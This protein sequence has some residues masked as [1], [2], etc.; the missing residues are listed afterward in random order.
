MDTQLVTIPAFLRYRSAI[1][2]IP[3][4][5]ALGQVFLEVDD[6]E[7]CDELIH[8][9]VYGFNPFIADVLR[10]RWGPLFIS[11]RLLQPLFDRL[12]T[13]LV[14][15]PGQI[16]GRVALRVS[17]PS[18]NGVGL[19]SAKFTGEPN[20]R[21]EPAVRRL[22]RKLNAHRRDFGWLPVLR[23]AEIPDLG[24]SNHLAGGLPMRA[25]PGPLESD[26]LGR[27]YGLR[28]VHV[29]DGACFSDL[30]AEHLTYTIMANATRIAAQSTEGNL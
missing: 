13:M 4:A 9:Q 27:P 1:G 5:I 8:L 17:S 3:K 23:L 12:M 18:Q 11:E 25:A 2:A 10:A 16:S 22:G 7:I 15:L 21:T 19:P 6:P 26:R 20:P 30:P 28:R 29:V 24:T 14:Y